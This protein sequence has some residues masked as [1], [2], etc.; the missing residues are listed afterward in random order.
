MRYDTNGYASMSAL[1]ILLLVT[2]VCIPS[3]F[4]LKLLCNF[5]KLESDEYRDKYGNFYQDL[6]LKLGRRVLLL[7]A[8]YIARRTL[9][10]IAV[11]YA[12]KTLYVQ[13]LIL[14]ATSMVQLFILAAGV[15]KSASD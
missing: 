11:L 7:P 10:A 5:E 13:I 6:N 2:I 4:L 1:C 9:L 12:S 15:F 14:I 8:F 3:I